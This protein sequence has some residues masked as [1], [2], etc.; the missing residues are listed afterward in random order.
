MTSM[1]IATRLY[2]GFGA[3]LILTLLVAA[4]GFFAMQQV[5]GQVERMD[6]A[7]GLADTLGRAGDARLRYLATHDLDEI[8]QNEAALQ[9]L[10]ADIEAAHALPWADTEQ[11]TL[12]SMS[13][14]L[15]PYREAREAMVERYRARLRA[16]ADWS[17]VA[18]RIGTRLS[19]LSSRVADAARSYDLSYG[20]D[21]DRLAGQVAALEKLYANIRF[22]LRGLVIDEAEAAEM[23]VLGALGAVRSQLETLQKRLP[24]N[25][26]TELDNL[27]SELAEFA[28]LVQRYRPAVADELAAAADMQAIA[29]RLNEATRQLDASQKSA[30]SELVARIPLILLAVA[31]VAILLGGLIAWWIAR[32]ITRPLRQTVTFAERIAQGDLAAAPL[33]S[34][35][36]E[37]GQLQQAMETM[38]QFLA[39]A[40]AAVRESA[41]E[42][43][44]G[45]AEIAAGNADLSSRSEQQAASLEQT[46]ASM[47]QL[48]AAVRH[49]TDNARQAGDLAVQASRVAGEGGESA[50]RLVDTMDG[51]ADSSRQ[52]GDIIGVIESIAFQT[53]ILA[54]NAAVEAARAGSQGKGFAVVA[55]EV[56]SLAQRSAEAAR[57]IKTLIGA[58]GDRV[59][60][61]VS[62]VKATAQTM[63]DIVSA[64]QRATDLMQEIAAASEQQLRGIEQVNQAVGQ[65][66]GTTQQN[67][68]LVEEAA[69][70][71][72][73]LEQQAARLQE[74]VAIFRLQRRDAGADAHDE[75]PADDPPFGSGR[76]RALPA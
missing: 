29:D 46:A 30:A 31:V 18:D 61:G 55:A 76:Q 64:V 4:V 59:S 75:S 7:S 58:S 67:A 49:N 62:Q 14:Q 26:T 48:A 16:R 54:L 41:H 8:E 70:A 53:N 21:A 3:V 33:A 73:S 60:S 5:N 72:A 1:R 27:L 71:A 47:E 19:G 34:R 23:R 22:T 6:A 28:E 11:A 10:E 25:E 37:V 42:I 66:D 38:R 13:S 17:S 45:S 32:Q 39:R 57:E 35:G 50:H 69:A 2:L 20:L 40:V 74:A 15:A 9:A 68:A 56:R 52:I 24:A 12:D 44:H 65:M 63:A 36:D 51:I 43:H